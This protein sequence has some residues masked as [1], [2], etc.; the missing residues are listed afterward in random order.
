MVDKNKSRK[1]KTPRRKLPANLANKRQREPASTENQSNEEPTVSSSSSKKL[2]VDRK[3]EDSPESTGHGNALVNVDLLLSLLE[4]FP[5]SLCGGSTT[6]S[7]TPIY[8]LAQKAV[9]K[10][11]SC[12]NSI[13]HNL[14]QTIFGNGKSLTH[15]E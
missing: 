11:Q 14:N 8:G 9:I 1:S 2:K 13:S 6:A 15:S 3:S 4:L 10:C 12:T 5:C 7:I